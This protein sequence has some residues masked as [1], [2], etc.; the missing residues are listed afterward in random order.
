M[1]MTRTASMY[2]A[3]AAIVSVAGCAAFRLDESVKLA[4]QSTPFSV[5]PPNATASLLI[6]GDS[7]GVGTGAPTP[8]TSLAGQLS[9]TYTR[10]NVEN[11]AV[12]GAK[13]AQVNMQLEA[14]TARH[15]DVV[16]IQA[17]GNDVIQ[18]TGENTLRSQVQLALA[19]AGAL[20]PLV[21]IMPAGN[22]GNAPLFFP[23]L[24]WWMTAR[25]QNLHRIV[26]EEATH[27]GAYYVNLYKPKSEDPFA[28]DSQNLH[29]ADGLH[30][31]DKGYA[32]WLTALI[33]QS[34]LSLA[35]QPAL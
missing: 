26:R 31:S 24:S 28:Q 27:A 8:E 14:A 13:F 6:V 35:L 18:L 34:P 29:A 25:S 21:I 2:V 5:N 4:K 23:P 16:L 11:L 20:A 3:L 9:R 22:L 19:Q 1:R 15:F 33:A 10:L 30:P 17:G 32:Q 7:T 12:N